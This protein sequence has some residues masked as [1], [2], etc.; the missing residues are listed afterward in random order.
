MKKFLAVLSLVCMLTVNGTSV[1]AT[2]D[3]SVDLKGYEEVQ[4]TFKPHVDE[5]IRQEKQAE[6]ARK[7]AIRCK[8]AEQKRREEEARKDLGRRFG[9]FKI[10]YYWIGE[11]RWGYRTAMGVRSS[12]FYTVAVDPDIVPL[13]SILTI[14]GEEYYAVDT[15]NKVQGNVIDIF[16]EEPLHEKWYTRDVKI[17]RWGTWRRR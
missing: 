8:K 12:R 14:N 10:T 3:S 1:N 15:G 9:T 2:E 13:G 5:K 11:D 17:V 16:S 6:K 4:K 7:E